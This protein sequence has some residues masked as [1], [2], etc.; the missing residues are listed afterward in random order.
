[1]TPEQTKKAGIIVLHTSISVKQDEI[2][3]V[4]A[5]GNSDGS[6]VDIHQVVSRCTLTASHQG[7]AFTIRYMTAQGRIKKAGLHKRKT[8]SG[9]Q[10][11]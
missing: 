9:F 10:K 7:V 3:K 6:L 4:I 2:L 5:K 11:K 1:M 8:N